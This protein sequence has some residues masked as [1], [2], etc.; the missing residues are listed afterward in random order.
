MPWSP[1]ILARALSSDY[2]VGQWELGAAP[3]LVWLIRALLRVKLRTLKRQADELRAVPRLQCSG[4]GSSGSPG[5]CMLQPVIYNS[6]LE[7]CAEAQPPGQ[8]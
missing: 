8:H 5:P 2:G 1:A 7:L 6:P 4:P 3:S